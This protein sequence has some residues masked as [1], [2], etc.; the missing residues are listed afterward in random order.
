MIAEGMACD[1]ESTTIDYGFMDVN[2]CAQAVIDAGYQFFEH[3]PNDGECRYEM[4]WDGFCNEGL[5]ESGYYDFYAAYG[6]SSGATG[7][8]YDYDDDSWYDSW[9][10]EM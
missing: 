7:D 4:T 2:D 1:S 8:W 10:E 3:D 5:Y 9:Y 6:W